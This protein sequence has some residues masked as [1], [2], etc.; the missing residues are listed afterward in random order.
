MYRVMIIDDEK[1]LRNLLIKTIPW[2]EKGLVVAGEAA[3]G[4][5]AINTIDEVR[6]DIAFVDVKM[7]FMDGI[8]FS[9]LAIERYPD[10]KI[11]ILTAFDNFN[12]A[13][14]CIGIG[15]C[16]Y[17]LKPIVRQDISDALDRIITKLD[18]GRNNNNMGRYFL[19]SFIVTG[20]TIL[21]TVVFALM[22]LMPLADW[23]GRDGKWL[24]A[25]LCWD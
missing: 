2:N 25:F 17:I 14:D 4:I 6:P 10:L 8:A 12:Y 18:A 11:L 5:E 1:A 20:L 21:F 7:P 15:I 13:R 9:K 23:N 3:S 22:L 24:T 19:N 16:E